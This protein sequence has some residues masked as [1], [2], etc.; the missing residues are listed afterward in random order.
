MRSGIIPSLLVAEIYF[1]FKNMAGF[2]ADIVE[3]FAGEGFYGSF[4][5]GDGLGESERRR[6]LNASIQNKV[7]ITQWLTFL[8]DKYQLDVSALDSRLRLETVKR[9]KDNLYLAAECGATNIAFVTGADPGIERRSNAIEGLYESLCLISEEAAN[10]NIKVLVEHL[11]REAHKKRL[12][13]PIEEAVA[14]ISRVASSYPNIGLAFDTAHS[15]L[16]GENVI[17]ALNCAKPVIHQI[18]FS[19]AVLDA[20]SD[21]YGDLHMPLG[22]PGFLNTAT[23]AR[24]LEQAD[25]LIFEQNKDLR[26]AVEVRGTNQ[27][28]CHGNEKIARAALEQAFS[29]AKVQDKRE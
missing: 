17:S 5:I 21:L 22:E 9:I 14:L 3:R 4:E 16:N 24:I 29:L 26:V 6:I 19:N 12:I 1:P 28:D 10:Y 13:G 25:K 7:E 18:H 20:S 8:L 23:M 2:T 11:D 15:A 27:A